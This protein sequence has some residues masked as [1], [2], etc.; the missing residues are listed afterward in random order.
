M[1][2]GKYQEL[3]DYYRKAIDILQD[4]LPYEAPALSLSR[5]KS[6]YGSAH[7]NRDTG[8][9]DSIQLSEVTCWPVEHRE[10]LNTISHEI[11]HMIFFKHNSGHAAI[12]RHFE[13]I[14]LENWDKKKDTSKSA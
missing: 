11:G 7:R 9:I 14:L 12:T 3:I 8:R 10:L 6:Y 2:R 4:S 1:R 5:A 13:Q